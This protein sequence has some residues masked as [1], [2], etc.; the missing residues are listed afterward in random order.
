MLCKKKMVEF[1]V[2]FMSLAAPNGEETRQIRGSEGQSQHI[3][4]PEFSGEVR[5]DRGRF[6]TEPFR[7]HRDNGSAGDF[8]ADDARRETNVG[9][10]VRQL[11]R[12]YHDQVALRKQ[13]IERLES[14]IQEFEAIQQEIEK[15]IQENS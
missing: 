4:D 7:T 13:E 6:G 5:P 8:S 11:I 9:K 2:R 12:E 14:K 10:I 3:V 1:C 15:G